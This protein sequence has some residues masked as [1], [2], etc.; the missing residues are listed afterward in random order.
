MSERDYVVVGGGSAGAAVAARLSE[1]PDNDVLV[2]EAGKDWRSDEAPPEIRSRNFFFALMEMKEE[3]VWPGMSGRLTDAQEYEHYIVGKGLGGG[4][5]VNAQFFVRPPLSDFDTWAEMGATGWSSDDVLPYFTRAERDLEL[6]DRPHHG[7]DG[8]IPVWRPDEDDWD[9]LDRAF[10]EAARDLGY[11]ESPDRDYNHPEMAGIS[12]V[13]Y[14]MEDGERVSTNEG[15]LEPARGR[16]NLTVLGNTLV[17]TVLFE[18]REAVGVEAVR[19]GRRDLFFG[20]TVILCAGAIQTPAILMRS[21]VGP[22]TQLTDIDVGVKL[23]KPGMGRLIDHPLFTV[24]YDIKE[25]YRADPPAPDDF[26]S[27]LLLAWSS[28]PPFGRDLDMQLHNQNFIGTTESALEVGGL[29]FA[30]MDIYSRG[31]IEITS[32]DPTETPDIWVDMLGD[33][34]DLVR[35]RVGLRDTFEIAQHDA[36]QELTEGE[37]E[38]APREGE[39]QSV[40]AFEDDDE[41]FEQEI[42]EQCAQ[43]FHPVGTCRMGDPNDEMSVVDPDGKVIGLED[44]YVA[45]ASIMPDIVRANTNSTCIMIGEHIAGKLR[46]G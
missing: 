35:V 34:R 15:Y 9:A 5:T 38:F 27:S 1:D 6:G 45:D 12:R 18:G 37:P 16:D 41:A 7:D 29:V 46:Q 40:S 19:D 25:K 44:L 4:S 39:G 42:L 30:L 31:R 43:Y 8:P 14:N 17:D 11:P 36:I 2:L 26:Y 21:G 10:Y 22:A 28:D 3:F 24:T 13:P 20:D 23:D 32:D 33:R